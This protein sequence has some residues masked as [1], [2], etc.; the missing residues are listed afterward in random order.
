MPTASAPAIPATWV[1]DDACPITFDLGM[2]SDFDGLDD[3]CDTS[4]DESSVAEAV[5]TIVENVTEPLVTQASDVPG[6]NGLIQK[7]QNIAGLVN[8]ATAAFNDGLLTLADYQAALALALDE[9]DGFDQQLAAKSDPTKK[10][11]I[12][13]ALAAAIAEQSAALGAI[14]ASLIANAG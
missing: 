14:I 11:H 13:A 7:L 4:F 2:D 9:L 12:D 1:A 8:D 5:S 6:V 10:K 3:A